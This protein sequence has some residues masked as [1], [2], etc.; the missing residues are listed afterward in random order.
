[1]TSSTVDE[2]IIREI[3]TFDEKEFLLNKS[4]VDFSLDD[5]A[6]DKR[7]HN[8]YEYRNSDKEFVLTDKGYELKNNSKAWYYIKDTGKGFLRGGVKLTEGVGSLALATLEKMNIVSEGS[9]EN[10]ANFY[11]ENIYEKIGDT[12]TMA[13]GFAEGIGQFI[14]PGIGTNPTGKTKR[15]INLKKKIKLLII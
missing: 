15:A 7:W 2:K 11:Q 1:M 3:T 5:D 10:F 14:V 9:V 8:T 6:Y 4:K 12:E 13:G